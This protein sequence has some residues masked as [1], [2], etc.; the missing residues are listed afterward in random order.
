MAFLAPG[1][2]SVTANMNTHTR[3]HTK[4]FTQILPNTLSKHF[5]D[6]LFFALV[7]FNNNQKLQNAFTFCLA[8]SLW[9]QW[10]VLLSSHLC[11]VQMQSTKTKT[12]HS[13][14]PA[15]RRGKVLCLQRLVVQQRLKLRNCF[16]EDSEIIMGWTQ[17]LNTC[18]KMAKRW[19]LPFWFPL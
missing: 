17:F 3:T 13:N 10:S 12:P 4:N 8:H 7:I 11:L 1:V 2:G 18:N 5:R 6:I 16:I 14:G 15:R 9:F 19:E